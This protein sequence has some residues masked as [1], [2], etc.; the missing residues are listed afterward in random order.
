MAEVELASTVG[1]ALVNL[2][3][4]ATVLEL[5]EVMVSE[6][7]I[8]T[9]P[10]GGTEATAFLASSTDVMLV[11]AAPSPGLDI[12]SAGYT[13]SSNG[14]LGAGAAGNRISTFRMDPIKSDRVEC[15]MAF[16]QKVVAPELGAFFDNVLT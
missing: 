1:P 7:V 11:Y 5:E 6:A 2:Q 3:L 9:G 12:P 15:E 8:N 14:L 4:L 13:F 16:D 10:E